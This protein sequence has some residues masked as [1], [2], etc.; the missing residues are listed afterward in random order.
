MLTSSSPCTT[1]S[2]RLQD[3]PTKW[4]WLAS[5][6]RR[7][8]A[9][10][11]QRTCI[12]AAKTTCDFWVSNSSYL[13]TASQLQPRSRQRSPICG[14]FFST[15]CVLRIYLLSM[16]LLAD[17]L[18]TDCD[19]I[20]PN[21]PQTMHQGP[22]P[23]MNG[24]SLFHQSGTSTSCRKHSIPTLRQKG[25]LLTAFFQD[26]S[27]RVSQMATVF[28][29]PKAYLQWRRSNPPVDPLFHSSSSHL[30][31]FNT[32]QYKHPAT[33]CPRWVP[34]CNSSSLLR[35]PWLWKET[36]RGNGSPSSSCS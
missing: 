10:S 5:G 17:G 34:H 11:K 26:H 12:R 4:Q 19:V 35:Q 29:A 28:Q 32:T 31:V 2:S 1:V 25:N 23:Q 14:K 16:R 8:G 36:S 6:H 27:F 30:Q 3:E 21:Q 20:R 22:P 9:S 18:F 15:H 33:L 13:R 7:W 24:S